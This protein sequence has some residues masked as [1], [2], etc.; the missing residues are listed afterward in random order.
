MRAAVR[1]CSMLVVVFSLGCGPRPV[2]SGRAT[3]APVVPEANAHAPVVASPPAASAPADE[4]SPEVCAGAYADQRQLYLDANVE[5]HPDREPVF[6]E[7]C[8][9]LSPALQR[10]ASPLY[11][12]DRMDECERARDA[13]TRVESD[14]WH[15]MF[16]VLTGDPSRL[17]SPPDAEPAR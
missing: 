1:S 7:L 16:D 12:V 5:V 17:G 10:C 13:A 14:A 15:R 8:R 3:A 6:V 4:T 11:Q 9:R 2:A